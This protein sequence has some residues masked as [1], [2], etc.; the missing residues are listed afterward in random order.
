MTLILLYHLHKHKRVSFKNNSLYIHLLADQ[1]RFYNSYALYFHVESFLKGPVDSHH[2]FSL[3]VPQYAPSPYFFQ[4]SLGRSINV[5]FQEAQ[6]RFYPFNLLGYQL[7][8]YPCILYSPMGQEGLLF[9]AGLHFPSTHLSRSW[10]HLEHL[11]M[12][13]AFEIT[14]FSILH[15]FLVIKISHNIVSTDIRLMIIILDS[16]NLV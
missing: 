14:A 15:L 4:V 13:S 12:I 8:P 11:N 5:E 16:M 9:C 3:V 10:T 1:Q 2:H 6:T 7:M